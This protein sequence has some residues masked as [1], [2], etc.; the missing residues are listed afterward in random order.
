MVWVGRDPHLADHS[1][2]EYREMG[3]KDLPP[4]KPGI[5]WCEPPQLTHLQDSEQGRHRGGS[6]QQHRDKAS[7]PSAHEAGSK[8]INRDSIEIA[9]TSSKELFFFWSTGKKT[10]HADKRT[11]SVGGQQQVAVTASCHTAQAACCYLQSTAST[12][13]Q[14]KE[15]VGGIH[16]PNFPSQTFLLEQVSTP[17]VTLS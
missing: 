11:M 1:K 13:G 4:S 15:E 2:E 12:E 16:S 7:S 8:W 10:S 14:M 6:S 9:C 17:A 3:E 5:P